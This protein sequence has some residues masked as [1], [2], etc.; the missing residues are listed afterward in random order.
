MTAVRLTRLRFCFRTRLPG[1]S[2]TVRL[3]VDGRPLL[4]TTVS[5]AAQYTRATP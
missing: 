4:I 2:A 3:F 1:H 5:R